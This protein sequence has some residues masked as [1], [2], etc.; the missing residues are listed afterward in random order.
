V[1]CGMRRKGE[2]K[3]VF[4]LSVRSTFFFANMSKNHIETHTKNHLS[5]F[6]G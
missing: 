2:Q 4:L 1:W 5:S 6:K 3:N